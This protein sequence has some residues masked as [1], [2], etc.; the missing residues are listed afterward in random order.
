MTQVE[1]AG[2]AGIAQHTLS[3]IE[4]GQMSPSLEVIEKIAAALGVTEAGLLQFEPPGE[5]SEDP[6]A[7]L[8]DGLPGDPAE[9]RVRLLR[10]LR[11]LTSGS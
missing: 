6:V 4:K 7:R 2:R 1:V 9:L 10:A 8:V 3:R 5:G 11:A